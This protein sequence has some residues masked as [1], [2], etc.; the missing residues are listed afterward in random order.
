VISDERREARRILGMYA[1]GGT[2]KKD[3]NNIRGKGRKE[4][5]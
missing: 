2:E 4:S 1:E 3:T 5:S